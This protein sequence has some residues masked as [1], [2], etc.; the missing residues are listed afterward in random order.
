MPMRMRMAVVICAIAIAGAGA[1]ACKKNKADDGGETA[2]G[3]GS[4][5]AAAAAAAAGTA[6]ATG[7]GSAAGSATDIDVPADACEIVVHIGPDKL[8]WKGPDNLAGEAAIKGGVLDGGALEAGLAAARNKGCNASVSSDAAATYQQIVHA[9][10]VLVKVGITNIALDSGDDAPSKTAPTSTISRDLK[11]M[12]V[13][14]V[15]K[16]EILLNGKLVVA[17]KDASRAEL[18]AALAAEQKA[19]PGHGIILQ[20]DAASNA[21]TINAVV[22]AAKK[23][24]FDNVLFAVKNK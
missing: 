5:T 21:A 10:D 2:S 14:V 20:A 17:V 23:A 16:T 8:T 3:T 18:D 4:G 9:M 7:S 1:G 6:A 22:A 15:S 12:P 19:R 13:V 11:D 24:G